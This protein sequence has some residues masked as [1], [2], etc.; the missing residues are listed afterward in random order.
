[1]MIENLKCIFNIF[2]KEIK[3]FKTIF[4]IFTISILIIS[5]FFLFFNY[6]HTYNYG[7]QAMNI[8]ATSQID[9]LLKSHCDL[10]FSEFVRSNSKKF[11]NTIR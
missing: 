6:K 11:I 3:K 10:P 9:K 1:M 5:I 4:L 2:F 7:D 8:I